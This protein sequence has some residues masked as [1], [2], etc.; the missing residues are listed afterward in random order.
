MEDEFAV[1]VV[2]A[3]HMK[4]APGHKTD[5]KSLPRTGYGDAE[6]IAELL[7]HG[8]LRAGFIPPR[9]QRELRELTRYRRSLVEERS[10]AVNRV[11]KL[12]EGANIKLASVATDVLAALAEGETDPRRW[13][14]W[15]VAGCGRNWESWRKPC[16]VWWGPTSATCRPDS[17]TTWIIW[18]RR[19]KNWTERWP[20]GCPLL[21]QWRRRRTPSPESDSAPPRSSL[22]KWA[23]TWSSFPLPAIRR[24]GPGYALG[25]NRAETG[26]NGLPP[27]KATVG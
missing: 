13:P 25:T 2:N 15:H 9:P 16:G 6:W 26:A 18:R 23:R 20:G 1:M 27:A 7:Q 10:R 21:S 22:R 5:V 4:T 3:A 8:L 14:G 24:L 17:C 11:Q 12:P 19:L